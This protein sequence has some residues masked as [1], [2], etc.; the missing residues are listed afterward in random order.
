VVDTT[1]Y[2]VAWWYLSNT[3]LD[4]LNFYILL[5]L[6]HQSKLYIQSAIKNKMSLVLNT[7]LFLSRSEAFNKVNTDEKIKTISGLFIK[8]KIELKFV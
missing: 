5:R 2:S 7:F 3:K 6:N 1:C 8:Q 4:H